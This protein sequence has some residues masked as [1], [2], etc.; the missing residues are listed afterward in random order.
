MTENHVHEILI[1]KK[2]HQLLVLD[3]KVYELA[4]NDTLTAFEEYITEDYRA[5]L[6][7]HIESADGEWFMAVFVNE[8]ACHYL[9]QVLPV[10]EQPDKLHITLIQAEGM[11]GEYQ[12]MV[13]SYGSQKAMLG[14]FE[15]M[16]FEYRP[17]T[18]RFR[19]FNAE[20]TIFQDGIH[21]FDEV[22]DHL[23]NKITPDNELA[24]KTLI[25]HIR[26]KTPSFQVT[27][28]QNLLNED[29]AI[30]DTMFRGIVAHHDNKRE[31]VVGQIHPIRRRGSGAADNLTYDPLTGLV[32]KLDISR[33]AT[34]RIDN[35]CITNTTL[36]IVD[37]DYFK[38]VNDSHGH[39]FGDVVLKEVAAIMKAEV[40]DDGTCGRIGGDEFLIIFNNNV[41]EEILRSHLRNIKSLVKDKFPDK[42]PRGESPITLSMGTATYPV[43]ATNY[44]DLFMIADYCLYMAKEKGRN[45]YVLYTPEKHPSLDEIRISKTEGENLV[46]G[47]ENLPLGDVLVQMLFMIRFGKRPSLTSL[48]PEFAERFKI[49]LLMLV[50]EDP[51]RVLLTTGP[52]TAEGA[53]VV[54][55]LDMLLDPCICYTHL[56]KYD[57]VICNNIIHLPAELRPKYSQRLQDADIHSFVVAPFEDVHG[58]KASLLFISL[59]QN[60]VWNESHYL[61]YK[62]FLDALA[63]Y[64]LEEY[65]PKS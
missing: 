19:L 42:G 50:A 36:A 24:L 3:P 4:N 25:Q 64:D 52:Q 34:D 46:N 28:S 41:D 2:G 1:T 17:D 30:T 13:F 31:S 23:R 9:M 43:H 16:F 12:N 48:L 21:L 39:Q 15:D 57:M 58:R 29:P 22:A 38:N 32:N 26:G 55:E 6:L 5:T 18:D 51:D 54:K 10:P 14:L 56:Y 45:R 40:G 8:P 49:P 47:R 53:H 59:H 62:L 33:L 37:I 20:N 61:Y 11:I 27:F 7:Q 44:N 35:R 63:T 60:L 65:I